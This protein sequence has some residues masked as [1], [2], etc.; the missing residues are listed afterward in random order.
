MVNSHN[1]SPDTGT[2]LARGP[3]RSPFRPV[4]VKAA[5]L[6]KQPGR[7]VTREPADT[8]TRA[9]ARGIQHAQYTPKPATVDSNQRSR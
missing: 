9:T 8:R 2:E 5:T 7:W 1:Y 6:T 3:G 4:T